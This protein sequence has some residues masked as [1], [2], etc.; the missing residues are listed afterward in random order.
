MGESLALASAQPM[1]FVLTHFITGRDHVQCED[2]FRTLV[3]A[4]GVRARERRRCWH[5][6]LCFDARSHCQT[7]V[8]ADALGGDVPTP[9]CRSG[10]PFYCEASGEP[11]LLL[12]F[13]LADRVCAC[14]HWWS[15]PDG[16]C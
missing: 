9:D 11:A 4:Q 5:N 7:T 10:T 2:L 15:M 1:S 14:R 12:W 16:G 3:N 8:C 6:H 13:S